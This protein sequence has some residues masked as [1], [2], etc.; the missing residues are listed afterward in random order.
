M[1]KLKVPVT[2][3]DH[4]LGEEEAPAVLVEYGDYQCPHCAHAQPVIHAL[5]K[6]FGERLRF[7][8]RHF[9]LSQIHPE[10]E[11]AAETAEFAAAQNRF[12]E[13]HDAIFK[14]QQS[15]GLPLL[16]ELTRGLGLSPED[17]L[18]ALKAKTYA[19]VVREQFMGG[20]RS[21]VNGTPTFFINGVRFDG[22]AG[23]EDLVEAIDAQLARAKI[24][25]QRAG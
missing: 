18:E 23:F 22:P 3:S 16:S 24:R 8:F 4:S 21:G 2:A 20:V 12:W 5:I 9:P 13:M 14:N 25:R 1:A 6:H 7:I 11:P 10:A 17:L 19:P 15:L